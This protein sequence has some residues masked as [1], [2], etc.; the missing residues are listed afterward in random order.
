[1]S[2]GSF[3]KHVAT[4]TTTKRTERA[5]KCVEDLTYSIQGVIELHAA[6][7][8]IQYSD[9]L[10]GQLP[11]SLAANAFNT[12]QNAMYSQE[13]IR[14]LALWDS[15]DE[16]AIS[17][18][19][20]VTLIDNDRVIEAL[21]SATFDAHAQRDVRMLNPSDD[22]DIQKIVDEMIV[23]HQNEFAGRQAELA[24]RTLKACIDEVGVIQARAKTTSIRNLRNHL[25]HSVSKTRREEK[26]TVPY[27]KF[28]YERELLELTVRL[29]ED[30]Y[31]WVN[32]TSFDISG[33]CVEHAVKCADELWLNCRFDL[34][35]PS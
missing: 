23:E 20:V 22:P 25:A 31:C 5:K 30:L 6:N 16:N 27:S 7:K 26:N 34:E 10:S 17:I 35:R 3:E 29:V 2:L 8:I 28:G 11:E 21:R 18:P 15:A 33:D 14:L 13:I 32:G 1:V 24:A 9:Q 12:F 19:T 4:W